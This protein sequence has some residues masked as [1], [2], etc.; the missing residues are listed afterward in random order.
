M[1]ADPA[2]GAHCRTLRELRRGTLLASLPPDSIILQ[3]SAVALLC[4][5]TYFA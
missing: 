4:P 5:M 1:Q 2:R 3:A